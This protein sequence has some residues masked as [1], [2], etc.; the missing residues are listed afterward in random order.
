M[1]AGVP[2][3]DARRKAEMLLGQ[4]GLAERL[5]HRPARL[6]GGEQQRVAIVRAL[7]ND[8]KILLADEPTGNLDPHTADG[9][10]ATLSDIVRSSGLAALIA[11]HNLDLARRLDRHRPPIRIYEAWRM[12][13]PSAWTIG[14]KRWD[15]GSSSRSTCRAPPA[16]A[17]PPRPR[18]SPRRAL[19]EVALVEDEDAVHLRRD[20]VVVR[21]DEGGET[22]P[23]DK[24]GQRRHGRSSAVCG[25]RLP[26]GSSPRRTL[27]AVGEGAHDRDAL[28][29][30]A[31][32]PRRA[33]RLA[34]RE[35]DHPQ[36]LAA[37]HL[38][39]PARDAGDHLRHDDVLERGEFGQQVMELV[40]ETKLRAAHL[41]ALAVR[42]LSARATVEDDVAAVGP[43]QKAGDVEERRLA[44]ARRAD[45]RDELARPQRRRGAAQDGSF[46]PACSKVRTTARSSSASLIPERLDRIEARRAPGG[47]DGREERERERHPGTTATSPASIFAG[48]CERK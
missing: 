28:L 25:S 45:Q 13:R 42:H 18:A 24:V 11:T 21:R 46:S 10:M 16:S 43:L 44:G 35:A 6:S 9:V 5:D 15:L 29:L 48:S 4:V 40:D 41:G 47:I 1:I 37:A 23:A 36:K 7:A 2:R 31:R 27:G 26:V 22:R 33:V 17:R 32:E 38:G 19:D 8:P 34:M 30:A 14:R 3:A 12:D 39:L 20:R